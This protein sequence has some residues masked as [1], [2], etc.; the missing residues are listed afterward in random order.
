MPTFFALAILAG[1]AGFAQEPPKVDETV[2]TR[3]ESTNGMFVEVLGGCRVGAPDQLAC[4]DTSGKPSESLTDKIRIGLLASG[5]EMNFRFGRSLKY[6]VVRRSPNTGMSYQRATGNHVNTNSLQRSG[7]ESMYELLSVRGDEDDDRPFELVASV[8][9]AGKPQ[10]AEVAFRKGEKV[11]FGNV[12]Y[13]LGGAVPL[14]VP[15]APSPQYFGGFSGPYYPYTGTYPP[16]SK[17]WSLGIG[18]ERNQERTVLNS[19]IALDKGGR[20]IRFV[21]KNGEPVRSTDVLAQS[22]PPGYGM[23]YDPNTKPPK[24]RTAIV[25]RGGNEVNGA[26]SYVININPDRI[27]RLQFYSTATRVVRFA[28]IPMDVKAP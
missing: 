28:P 16:D 11:R 9:N 8:H 17:L 2:Q 25:M 13:E 18:Y 1:N 7:D 20:E 21:D 10:T 27:G 6:V 19:I 12:E 14:K 23:P 26:F 15:K 24:Y 4:W 22:P 5:N 3:Y